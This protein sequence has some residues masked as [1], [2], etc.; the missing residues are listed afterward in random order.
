MKMSG[1]G[2]PHIGVQSTK[3]MYFKY[4][5]IPVDVF[6]LSQISVNIFLPINP[7]QIF[8]LYQ[9]IYTFLQK[10]QKYSTL[11][12]LRDLI[13]QV[14]SIILSSGLLTIYIITVFYL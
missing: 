12:H 14:Q 2:L 6:N 3:Y 1:K 7:L 10:R 4:N 11:L 13:K 5:N 8:L 9:Y